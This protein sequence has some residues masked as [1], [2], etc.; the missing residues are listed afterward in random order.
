MIKYQKITDISLVTDTVSIYRKYRYL[1]CRYD[2]DTD[3]LISAIDRR[4]FQYTDPPL[5]CSGC[6]DKWPK[7]FSL[8]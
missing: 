6:P 4:Y 5:V 2:T 1:K 3:I 8:D 7:V